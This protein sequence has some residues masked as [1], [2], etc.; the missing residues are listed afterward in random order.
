MSKVLV[1]LST[2]EHI[3]KA[4]FLPH[5]LGL[6][7][8]ENSFVIT[9]HGQSPAKA[10]NIIIEQALGIDATHVCFLDDDMAYPPDTLKRLLAHDKDVV[11]ALYLMRSYPHFPV[12]FD[13]A[14]DS[15]KCK[16]MFLTQDPEKENLVPIV[17][18]G[19]GFVLIKIDIFKKLQNPWVTLGEIEK[20]GWCDDVAFFNKVRKAG[21]EM[22]MD[23]NARCGHMTSM[24]LW[25]TY[26]AGRWHSE[27][28]NEG[29]NVLFPQTVPDMEQISVPK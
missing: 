6:E 10:R 5:F 8:P 11:T 20:D 27:Y 28:K 1:G 4:D 13:E 29:G 22:Y 12:A 3:R 9:V 7:K 18:C 19:F 2:M 24:V 25:P 14:F 23:L 15:G 26:L 17:N 21:F 16:F